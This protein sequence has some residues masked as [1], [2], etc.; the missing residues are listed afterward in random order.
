MASFYT[1]LSRWNINLEMFWSSVA[2]SALRERKMI[3]YR[4]FRK[5]LVDLGLFF[6]WTEG[7]CKCIANGRYVKAVY[8]QRHVCCF[9]VLPFWWKHGAANN[10][11]PVCTNEC[12][13]PKYN[14][15]NIRNNF[16]SSAMLSLVSG[17]QSKAI[18]IF[19]CFF[20]S[21]YSDKPLMLLIYKTWCGA[22]KGNI[23][24]LFSC[25]WNYEK[26]K[27]EDKSLLA[28]W[29]TTPLARRVEKTVDVSKPCL[30]IFAQG[31]SMNVGFQIELCVIFQVKF[32]VQSFWNQS[33]SWMFLFLSKRSR[34]QDHKL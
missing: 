3:A 21:C 24:L 30:K 11:V 31:H 27:P 1:F 2:L 12:M 19:H 18:E 6:A 20:S 23:Y 17:L 28:G 5:L 13:F 25:E 26:V 8:K 34:D 32:R 15:C 9:M 10:C 7:K 16:A 33:Q 4:C 22:C 14:Y 29:V